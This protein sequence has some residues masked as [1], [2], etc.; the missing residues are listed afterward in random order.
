VIGIGAELNGQADD[1][2]Q[3]A[4]YDSYDTFA[5]SPQAVLGAPALT[6]DHE[7]DQLADLRGDEASQRWDPDSPRSTVVVPSADG[8]ESENRLP[9]FEAVES[10]WFRRGRQAVSR[11]GPE[12][13]AGN[14][15][16]SPADEGWRAAE[17]VSAPT[18]GGVTSAGL[19]K[20]VPRANLVPGS[21]A[22]EA[23]AGPAGSGP[24]RSAAVTRDRFS[25]FQRG[26][27]EGRAAA[28]AD[29][30]GQDGRADDGSS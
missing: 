10:D 19:P 16:T 26:I 13:V 4:S 14:G 8:V 15:W 24:A 6:V 25:R 12:P 7:T 3:T 5:G 11:P 23:P 20:R 21:A 29:T 27:R 22:S 30:S 1:G 28:A 18:S 17:V 2:P 9:I